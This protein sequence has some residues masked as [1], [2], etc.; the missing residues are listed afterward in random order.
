MVYVIFIYGMPDVHPCHMIFTL[1]ITFSTDNICENILLKYVHF[2]K[3][4]Y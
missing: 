4:S 2:E 3:D 1:A